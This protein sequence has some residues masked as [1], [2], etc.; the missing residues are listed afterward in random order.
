V[1]DHELF[2]VESNGHNGH[3]PRQAPEAMITRHLVFLGAFVL[4][5]AAASASSIVGT[6][7]LVSRELPDGTKPK[8]VGLL[9]ISPTTCN[10]N[11]HVVSKTGL[12]STYSYISEYKLAGDEWSETRL[13]SV[14]TEEGVAK[15]VDASPRTGKTRAKIAGDRVEFHPPDFGHGRGPVL[16]FNAKGL[17]ATLSGEFVDTWERLKD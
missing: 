13:F 2:L 12:K 8:V 5:A 1:G 11:I 14:S 17:V 16:V 15:V 4:C 10:F 9:S 3:H 7:R 6:Y